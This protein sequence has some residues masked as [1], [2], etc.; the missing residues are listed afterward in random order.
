MTQKHLHIVG[1]C[2]VA[3]GALAIAFRNAG[4][5]VTGSDKGFYPPVSTSLDNA[6][7]D[8]YAGWHVDK[9]L[10]LSENSEQG[11]PDIIMIGGGGKSS[12]NPEMIYAKENNIPIFSYPEIIEKYMI[13]K[14]S[15]VCAGTWGKTTTSALLAFVLEKA[16]LNPTCMFGALSL[17]QD[18]SAKIS[19]SDQSDWSVIE[20]DEYTGASFDNVAKFFHYH[21]TH[22][23]LTSASWDHADVYPTEDSYLNAFRKLISE[24]KKDSLIIACADNENVNRLIKNRKAVSYGK[25]AQENDRM[26]YRADYRYANI[27]YTKDGLKFDILHLDKKYHIV[28]PMLGTFQAE[29]IAGVFAMAHQIGIKEEII[30]DAIAQFK[31][32]KRRLEKR[33]EGKTT[34]LDCHAPTPDKAKSALESIR[35]VYRGKIIAIFEPN[36]GGR[37]L[38]TISLYNNAFRDAD[39]VII[40]RLTKLKVE[41][42]EMN[43]SIEGDV[44][45]DFISKTHTNAL[46]I[47]DDQELIRQAIS[48]SSSSE[49]KNNDNVI[50]FLGSHGFRGMIEET[51]SQCKAK[52]A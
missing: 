24:M 34:I 4:W 47:E 48:E 23:L 20:G 17:S 51:V 43:R 32:I 27:H 1:I 5:K 12:I 35:E 40:P 28:S 3:T 25:N 44:L 45:K 2:G 39:L 26:D 14:N 9:M 15:I 29:N 11:K 52:N 16:K 19:P 38:E 33:Y 7:I 50:A 30:I 31:G 13:R 8:Y 46:F 22:L 21:P 6:K 42:G 10:K 41:S 49:A 37:Q 36:I 18:Q